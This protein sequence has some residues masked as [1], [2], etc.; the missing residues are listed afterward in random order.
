MACGH[1][2]IYYHRLLYYPLKE[3]FTTVNESVK[4]QEPG[5]LSHETMYNIYIEHFCAIAGQIQI[6]R[7][8]CTGKLRSITVCISFST[9]AK[10]TVETFFCL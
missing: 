5:K 1:S 2:V 6:L 7:F 3:G 9:P 10:K 8:Q 4:L